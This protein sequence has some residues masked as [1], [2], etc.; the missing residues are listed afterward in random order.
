MGRIGSGKSTAAGILKE[1]V[2]NSAVIDVDR[3]AKKIYDSDEN[4]LRNIK[5]VFGEEV[6]DH[7]GLCFEALADRVFSDT[8]ELK[9]LNRLMFPLIRS[10]IR[11]Q[12]KK[13]KDKD[14]LII[15]AAVLFNCKLDVLCDYVILVNASKKVR[16]KNLL[17]KGIS[18]PKAEMKIKGQK[19]RICRGQVDW[20]IENNGNIDKLRLACGRVYKDIMDKFGDQD[21]KV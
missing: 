7:R 18:E 12:I 1:K 4:I 5:A 6:F 9:K 20:S 8:A 19:I 21:E 14:F 16:K 11:N 2:K 17:N 3:L 13:H 15:D 10:E